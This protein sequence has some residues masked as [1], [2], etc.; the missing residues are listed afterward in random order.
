[1]CEYYETRQQYQTSVSVSTEQ[2][3]VD[4]NLP[5]LNKT[6][7]IGINVTMRCVHCTIVAVVKR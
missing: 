1:M 7:I 6:G 3:Y 4:Y 5:K 2:V